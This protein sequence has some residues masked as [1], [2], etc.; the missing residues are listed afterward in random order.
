VESTERSIALLL[1]LLHL[2]CLTLLGR[3]QTFYFEVFGKR[4]ICI[5]QS[6]SRESHSI[7]GTSQTIRSR[8]D[9][10]TDYGAIC[11]RVTYKAFSVAIHF[12]RSPTLITRYLTVEWSH[13]VSQIAPLKMA[14]VTHFILPDLPQAVPEGDRK[15]WRE[16]TSLTRRIRTIACH[17]HSIETFRKAVHQIL[18]QGVDKILIVGGNEK[19]QGLISTTKAIQVATEVTD[20]PVWC[21][22]NPND[23]ESFASL[24]SKAHSGAS[25]VVT[26]P[27]L[28][29]H[30]IDVFNSYKEAGLHCVAGIAFPKSVEGLHFWLKLLGQPDLVKDEVFQSHIAHFDGGKSSLDWAKAQVAHLAGT[31]SLHFMPMRN[32]LDLKNLLSDRKLLKVAEKQ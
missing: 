10:S 5:S 28:C 23:R 11:F 26:Q 1:Y 31:D 27:L 29:S 20:V 8:D 32:S 13:S 30:A 4:P 22:A 14:A 15:A 19:D 7:L 3:N 21:V 9:I 25:G 17:R 16:S 12:M 24:E 2:R 6:T 18:K